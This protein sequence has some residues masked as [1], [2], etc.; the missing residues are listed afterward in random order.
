MAAEHDGQLGPRNVVL[1]NGGVGVED[2]AEGTFGVF[3]KGEGS[4]E[5]VAEA[6]EGEEGGVGVVEVDD[7]DCDGAGLGEAGE[8]LRG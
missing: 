1:A 6:V 2:D 7:H 8:F 4:R 5:E 3:G